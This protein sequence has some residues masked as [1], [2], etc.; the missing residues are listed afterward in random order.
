MQIT[1]YLF[2]NIILFIS[3]TLILYLII[4]TFLQYF[5]I[6]HKNKTVRNFKKRSFFYNWFDLLP[7]N[8]AQFINYQNSSEFKEHGIILFSGEQGSGKT[9]AMTHAINLLTAQYPDINIYTN[10]SLLI[11]DYNLDDWKPLINANNGSNGIVFA[12]DEI[13]NWFNCR[14]YQSFPKE[15]LSELTYNRK[16]HRVIYGTCQNIANVDTQIRRQ[17]TEYRQCFCLFGFYQ[18]V[19]R[20]KPR[21]NFDGELEK[22]TFLGIYCFQQTPILRYQYDTFSTVKNLAKQGI[23]KKEV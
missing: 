22:K 16:N 4:D 2:K 19:I 9:M 15:L 21:F 6:P 3:L 8:I 12:F 7:R 18:I 5:L 11:Q 20:W 10:Y 13:S 17:C 23:E 1:F 14:S